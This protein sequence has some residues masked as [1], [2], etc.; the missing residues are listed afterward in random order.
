MD[1]KGRVKI[2]DFGLAK[3][4]GHDPQALRLTGEGQIMGTP[5]FPAVSG[6]EK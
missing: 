1:R 2:A 5:H 6:I 4:L 3:I